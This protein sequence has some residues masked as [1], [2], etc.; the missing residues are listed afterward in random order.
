MG[1]SVTLPWLV[2]RQDDDGG[3]YRVGR[4]ATLMEAQALAERL[5]ASSPRGPGEAG[6]SE[7]GTRRGSLATGSAE[8][9]DTPG[10]GATRIAPRAENAEG[11]SAGSGGI[12]AAHP[13]RYLVERLGY[14]GGPEA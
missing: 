3:R 12:G 8:R 5:T 1:E 10:G 9:R 11:E 2:I 6:Q 14:P 4:Y 7:N 13:R